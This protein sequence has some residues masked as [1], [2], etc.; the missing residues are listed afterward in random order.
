[1]SRGSDLIVRKN[2]L[3]TDIDKDPKWDGWHQI[4]YSI[5]GVP[6]VLSGG[7][8]CVGE[9]IED[10]NEHYIVSVNFEVTKSGL[11]KKV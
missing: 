8:C 5:E 4:H 1:M 3:V 11:P 6:Y 10:D 7:V 2:I 9:L